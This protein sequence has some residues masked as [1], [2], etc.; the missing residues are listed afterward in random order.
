MCV[1][2]VVCIVTKRTPHPFNMSASIS[3]ERVAGK[4]PGSVAARL[5]FLSRCFSFL[6]RIQIW[7]KK[8]SSESQTGLHCHLSAYLNILDHDSVSVLNQKQYYITVVMTHHNALMFQKWSF[9]CNS[10]VWLR[11]KRF[12]LNNYNALSWT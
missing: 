2:V 5:L 1:A 8:Y 7:H 10:S 3:Y 9:P 6:W 12:I 11:K 4:I